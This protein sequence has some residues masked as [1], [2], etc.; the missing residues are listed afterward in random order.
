M[1]GWI[2]GGDGQMETWTVMRKDECED[3]WTERWNEKLR[4]GEMN[5]WTD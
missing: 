1:E 2:Y 3:S 4:D 5:G